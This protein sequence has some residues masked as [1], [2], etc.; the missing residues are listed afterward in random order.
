MHR[1]YGVGGPAGLVAVEIENASGAP[2]VAALVLGPAPAGRMRAVGTRGSW[3]TVD[4]RP[5]LRSPRPAMRWAAGMR[6]DTLDLVTAGRA[7]ES[8]FNGVGGRGMRLEVALLHPVAHRTRLRCVLAVGRPGRSVPVEAVDLSLL[9]DA[10]VAAAGWDAQRRR[11]M[12]VVLPD[13]RLQ[14]AVDAGARRAAP[15][16]GRAQP[17]EQRGCRSSR[18]LGIRR[19]GG[20]CVAKARN[21]SPGACV[22][23]CARPHAMVEHPDPAGRGFGHV[24]VARRPGAVARGGARPP[25]RRRRE[26]RRRRLRRAARRAPRRVARPEPRSARRAD[27]RRS[28]LLRRPLARRPARAVVGVRAA[29]PTQRARPGPRLVDLGTKGETL[30]AAPAGA[31]DAGGFS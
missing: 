16:F 5:A 18:G 25:R 31:G 20:C 29:D 8:T 14:Q 21:S 24:L 27:V 12:R 23:S 3:V 17:P 1:A 13:A 6:G 28:R 9:P 2:F 22:A 4:G 10:A 30:L 15:R 26:R 7:Q 11:G 19:R